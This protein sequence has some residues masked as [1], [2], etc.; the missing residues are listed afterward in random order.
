MHSRKDHRR[1][2]TFLDVR[3]PTR[4]SIH[5]HT[6][7]SIYVPGTLRSIYHEYAT[8]EPPRKHLRKRKVMVHNI[9]SVCLPACLCVWIH[10][11]RL[12]YRPLHAC[13]QS[14]RSC[15]VVCGRGEGHN[16]RRVFSHPNLTHL[17]LLLL[18]AAG[19]AVCMHACTDCTEKKQHP[20]ILN[21]YT[22]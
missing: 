13:N 15:G 17:S 19:A 8:P 21:Q 22:A 6:H 12:F 11:H 18:L 2:K 4:P 7:T 20:D 3:V 9:P 1:R 16:N 14:K 10:H 5:V